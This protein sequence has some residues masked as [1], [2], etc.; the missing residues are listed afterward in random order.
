ME[1]KVMPF[2]GLLIGK[3]IF[4]KTITKGA[5]EWIV[6]AGLFLAVMLGGLGLWSWVKHDIISQHEAKIERRAAPA[7]D[8]AS[9]QRAN[10]TIKRT[11][12][13]KDAHDVIV[14]QPD[15]PIAP[16]SRAHACLQ[17]RRAG[18]HSSACQ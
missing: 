14:A 18:K 9:T 15:Q 3:S 16:T 12:E 2:I 13:Q 17:L 1:D 4:G 7:T 11:Q 5:A 8:A 10:D 6:S